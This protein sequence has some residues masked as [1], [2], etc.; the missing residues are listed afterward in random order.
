M[1]VYMY[2]YL[3]NYRRFG[4]IVSDHLNERVISSW[5]SVAMALICC[6]EFGYIVPNSLQYMG[7]TTSYKYTVTL[8]HT[9]LVHSSKCL[10]SYNMLMYNNKI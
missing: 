7:A 3:Y 6:K 9:P 10:R 2:T 4:I 8:P 1:H 5:S